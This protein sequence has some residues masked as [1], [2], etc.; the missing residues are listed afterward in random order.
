MPRGCVP[1][2]S[3]AGGTHERIIDTAAE[4]YGVLADVSRLSLAD[5]DASTRA[6]L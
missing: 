6:P 5:V 3:D 4:W 2:R 1:R